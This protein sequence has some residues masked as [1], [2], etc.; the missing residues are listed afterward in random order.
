[1]RICLAQ[2]AEAKGNVINSYKRHQIFID[3]ANKLKADLLLFPE[4]SLTG[5]EPEMADQL[6]FQ[7]TDGR[8]NIFQRLSNEN[9]LTLCIGVPIQKTH[10]IE[11]CMMI[12]HPGKPVHFYA[13]SLLHPDEFPYF[14]PGQ[15]DY[16]IESDDQIISPAICFESFQESHLQ[17]VIDRNTTIYLSSVAKHEKGLGQALP[18]F[19]E[20]SKSNYCISVMCNSIGTNSDFECAGS[21]TIW[22]SS[23]EIVAQL[24]SSSEGLALFDTKTMESL[25]VPF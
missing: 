11:I 21:S 6:V 20:F 17:K 8:F 9:R 12:C 2:I 23:G 7:A 14:V 24:D 16:F 15:L 18:F 10:G 19:S 13:K 4:L 22:N 3:E 1:M 25:T 5:Y